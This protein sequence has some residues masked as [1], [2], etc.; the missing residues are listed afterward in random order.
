L[1]SE[2]LGF[3]DVQKNIKLNGHDKDKISD[4]VRITT[5]AAEDQQEEYKTLSEQ[6]QRVRHRIIEIH[7]YRRPQPR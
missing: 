4:E 5:S 7:K 2:L 6:R 1:I 3:A